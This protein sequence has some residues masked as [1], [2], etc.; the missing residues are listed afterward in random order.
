MRRNSRRPLGSCSYRD[1]PRLDGWS[2]GIF[3]LLAK[4]GARIAG[5][6]RLPVELGRRLLAG[7]VRGG[8]GGVGLSVGV[9]WVVFAGR[10]G[11]GL[12]S[13]MP[14]N[15]GRLRP[16][17]RASAS[18]PSISGSAINELNHGSI[19][20]F[21][22]WQAMARRRSPATRLPTS[23][24]CCPSPAG[25]ARQGA[26][27]A[28]AAQLWEV[29]D[30]ADIVAGVLDALAAVG[31]TSI[32]ASRLPADLFSSIP[33][34]ALSVAR[35]VGGVG[36]GG[37]GGDTARARHPPTKSAALSNDA[38]RGLDHLKANGKRHPPSLPAP[39]AGTRW[40][41]GRTPRGEA[42]VRRL[43]NALQRAKTAEA[44]TLAYEP[45]GVVCGRSAELQYVLPSTWPVR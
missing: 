15:S 10:L 7:G 16:A 35:G 17:R 5:R 29:A 36:G 37:G 31:R 13:P 38:G 30:L 45:E 8:V 9:C 3:G 1:R 22:R 28:N 41:H 12:P 40:P 24:R 25:G 6:P 32:A 33:R 11:S 2:P 18:L 44:P 43:T 27:R 26:R 20:G 39:L 23:R 42:S 34:T 21:A 14:A 4:H 19:Y